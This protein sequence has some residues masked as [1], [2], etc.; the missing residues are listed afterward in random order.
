MSASSSFGFS[1]GNIVIFG[2]SFNLSRSSSVALNTEQLR[3]YGKH[4][5]DEIGSGET[6]SRLTRRRLKAFRRRLVILRWWLVSFRRLELLKFT[7]HAFVL[8]L[9]RLIL[10][11]VLRPI[12]LLIFRI[13]SSFLFLHR[14]L[15][16]ACAPLIECAAFLGRIARHPGRGFKSTHLHGAILSKILGP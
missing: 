5:R 7:A 15:E 16:F 9:M 12:L 6:R 1:Q 2:R 4:G 14:A 11:L 10:S 8:L 13:E 3:D